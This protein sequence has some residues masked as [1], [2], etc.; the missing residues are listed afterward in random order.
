LFHRRRKL[1]FSRRLQSLASNKETSDTLGCCQ[2]TDTALC[3][4]TADRI[5]VS[6][7]HHPQFQCD[8]PHNAFILE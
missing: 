5:N 2:L 6:R 7:L 1:T 8:G 4:T 3:R